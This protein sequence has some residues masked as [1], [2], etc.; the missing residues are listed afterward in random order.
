MNRLPSMAGAHHYRSP[1]ELD[2]DLAL[3]DET[4]V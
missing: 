4:L 3:L 1:H 2:E